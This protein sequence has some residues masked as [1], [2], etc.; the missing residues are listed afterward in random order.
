MNLLMVEMRRA[1]RRRVVRVLIVIALVG[2]AFAGVIAFSSRAARRLAE[3]QA[4]G[5]MH[6]AVMAD[7]WVAGAVRRR[8][9]H[10]GNV[11]VARR[12]VR[13]RGCRW[14]RMAGRA[15]SRRCSHGSHGVSG[16]T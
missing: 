5:D 2:C 9:A 16:S 15:R 6:P 7:W 13:G 12:V 14:R 10:R 11:P 3:L 1:M 8:R 4:N